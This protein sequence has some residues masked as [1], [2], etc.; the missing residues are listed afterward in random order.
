MSLWVKELDGVL[1][2]KHLTCMLQHMSNLHGHASACNGEYMPPHSMLPSS[3]GTHCLPC[4]G[5]D[6]VSMVAYQNK[7]LQHIE[8]EIQGSVSIDAL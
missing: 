6:T 7:L 8:H 1:Y 2:H 4:L 5:P 3:A